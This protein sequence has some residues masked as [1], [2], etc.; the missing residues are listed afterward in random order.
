M[1]S[2]NR[3]YEARKK[4]MIE[5]QQK[6]IFQKKIDETQRQLKN[7]SQNLKLLAIELKKERSKKNKI[8]EEYNLLGQKFDSLRVALQ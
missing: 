1:E 3:Q 4:L 8:I 6:E 2:E 5:I 7:Y